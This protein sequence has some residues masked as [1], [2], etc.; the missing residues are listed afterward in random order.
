MLN[1]FGALSIGFSAACLAL[2]CGGEDNAPAPSEEV[3]PPPVDDPNGCANN[4]YREDCKEDV[5]DPPPGT[6]GTGSVTPPAKPDPKTPQ[7]LAKEA[8]QNVLKTNCGGCHG[9]Q[10]SDLTA[11]AG[12]NYINDMDLLAK[13]NKIVPLSSDD[14][15]IIKRMRDGSMPPGG[16]RVS[17]TDI[18]IVANYIDNED[19]WPDVTKKVC[20]DNDPAD[21]DVLYDEIATDLSRQEDRDQPFIRYVSLRNLTASGVCTDTSLDLDRQALTKMLN[22]LSVDA[23]V[24][25]PEAVDK[26]QTLFRIDLQE[27]QWDRAINVNGQDFTDVWEAIVD[28]NPYAVPFVGDDADDAVADSGTTVPVMF[29]DSMLNSATIGNLYYSIIG[30]DVNQ[31]LDVFVSDV[32]DIDVQE[33]LDNEDLV[34]AGTT[35]SDISRQD[36]LVEGHDINARQGVYYQSFDFA[37]DQNES[38]FQDPFG[39]NEGGREAIFTLPNGMLAYLIADA[40]GNL[41]EDSDILLDSAQ[42]N[43]RA[44]TSVSCSNC[45]V[46]GFIPVV[47]E[48]REQVEANAILLIQDGTLNQDQLEQLSAVYLTPDKFKQKIERDSTLYL[49]ALRAAALPVSGV[50][51]V[52]R[53]FNRFDKDMPI[54]VAAGDLGVS[55][56]VLLDAL[57]L[58][59]PALNVLERRTIDRDDFTALYVNSLCILSQPNDNQPDA[60]ACAAAE[61]ALDN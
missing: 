3:D 9:T 61:A 19:Y 40:N 42:G 54:E 47:D 44:V 14:S 36:R 21:F 53:S 10:L 52:S 7:E 4:P 55:K 45:H 34:R 27:I 59:D 35:Q 56:A 5:V 60:A 29:L 39:F 24:Y 51:P 31:S 1:R 13:N 33:N 15:F 26:E 43:F 23:N 49:N 50:E 20:N 2:A 37:D 38:I 12:M 11:E 18:E 16:D 8:A 22:M 30:V 28:D 41:V 46:S 48:V 6:G 57:N 58:L 17:D 32:L 25:T